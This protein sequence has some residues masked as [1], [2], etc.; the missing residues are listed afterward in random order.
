MT[1]VPLWI[2]TLQGLATPLIALGVGV[3]GF[4]QWRTAHQKVVMDLFDRRLKVHEE[5]REVLRYYWTNE[6][7]LVGFNAGRKLASA[8]AGARFLFGEE[9]VETIESLKAIIYQLS[10]LKN[11]LEKIE[12]QGGDREPIVAEILEL[13]GHLDK[14]PLAFSKACL[15]YL[16]MDQ[17]HVRTPGEWFRDRNALRKSFGDKHQI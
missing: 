5:V 9:V 8:S 6:G 15:P 10:S 3:V 11:K 13:E 14:W 2:Q 1:D 4:M 12:R 7:N 16:R 17:K